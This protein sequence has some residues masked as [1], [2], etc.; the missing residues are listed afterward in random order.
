MQLID[1]SH[2][3]IGKIEHVC[4]V[5][6]LKF[7]NL[8]HN[9]I[10]EVPEDV[11]QLVELENLDLGFNKITILNNI[12]VLKQLVEARTFKYQG[13]IEINLE[14][15][16]VLKKKGCRDIYHKWMNPNFEDYNRML[17]RSAYDNSTHRTKK[18]EAKSVDQ[19]AKSKEQQILMQTNKTLLL[20]QNNGL[21]KSKDFINNSQNLTE[22]LRLSPNLLP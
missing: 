4:G 12:K 16:D 21:N 11:L 5:S 3:R 13:F 20:S 14:G 10:T 9:L 6:S 17:N 19:L 2:N 15:N 18:R 1:L 7:I 8:S 22:K